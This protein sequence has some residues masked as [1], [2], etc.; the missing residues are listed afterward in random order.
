M[1]C[2]STSDDSWTTEPSCFCLLQ[3][4]LQANGLPRGVDYEV[5]LFF[6]IIDESSSSLFDDNLVFTNFTEPDYTYDYEA[7]AEWSPTAAWHTINGLS[8]WGLAP[9]PRLPVT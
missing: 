4:E 2:V 1:T 5:P 9:L 7:W 6:S 8:W 3:G